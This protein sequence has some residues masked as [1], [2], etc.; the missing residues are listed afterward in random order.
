MSSRTTGRTRR[1]RAGCETPSLDE[2]YSSLDSIVRAYRA[3]FRKRSQ[4]ELD[5]FTSQSIADAVRRAGLAERLDGKRYNH[6]RRI[7]REVLQLAARRL[8]RANLNRARDF[9]ELHERVRE[10][11]SSIPGIGCLTIYDTALRIGAKLSLAPKRVYLHTGTRAGARKLGLN[12]RADSLAVSSVPRAFR[13]LEPREIE[14]VLFIFE[15]HFTRLRK[16]AV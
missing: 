10:T 11:I 5:S 9:D 7:P 3:R 8:G 13:E 2:R 16:S 15:D 6:Q 14:D 1:H 4:E 12:W